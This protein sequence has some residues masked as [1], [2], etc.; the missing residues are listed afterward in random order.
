[1]SAVGVAGTVGGTTA[2]CCPGP[3]PRCVGGE[4]VGKGDESVVVLSAMLQYLRRG[5]NP[6]ATVL[7]AS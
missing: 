2:S 6:R 7:N 3:G 5:T 1:M 4:A